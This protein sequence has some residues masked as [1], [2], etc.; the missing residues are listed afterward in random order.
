MYNEAVT[1]LE[2]ATEADPSNPVINDHLGDAYWQTG[3]KNEAGFQWNHALSLKD[4][5]GEIDPQTIK[6]KI[7]NGLQETKVLKSDK[8]KLTK[9]IS[10]IKGDATVSE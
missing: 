7:E 5:T 6:N 9:I 4:T 2:K 10:E 3:R 8:E 1:Y